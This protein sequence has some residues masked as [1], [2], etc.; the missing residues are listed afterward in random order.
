MDCLICWTNK[1]QGLSQYIPPRLTRII[2]P[3]SGIFTVIG[4]VFTFQDHYAGGGLKYGKN[5]KNI[6]KN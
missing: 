2:A 4:D 1:K 6:E 5:P 3:H